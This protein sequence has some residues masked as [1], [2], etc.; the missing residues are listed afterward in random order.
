MHFDLQNL[1]LIAVTVSASLFSL[2]EGQVLIGTCLEW[3]AGIAMRH[4]II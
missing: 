2:F 3:V 1:K 4:H